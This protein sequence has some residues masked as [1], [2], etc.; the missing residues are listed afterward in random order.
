M[1]VCS[2][3]SDTPGFSFFLF[4]SILIVHL[5][6]STLFFL[7]YQKVYV[8]TY[9]PPLYS[10]SWRIIFAVKKREKQNRAARVLK[11]HYPRLCRTANREGKYF[12]PL[13]CSPSSFTGNDLAVMSHTPEWAVCRSSAV[14]IS[15][16]WI[17]KVI[18]I[19]YMQ[20]IY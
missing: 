5:K 18:P 11:I 15:M 19:G 12:T 17:H 14:F 1:I 4:I 2:S 10:L 6:K 20:F 3:F 16:R 9:N 7:V 8:G 13:L